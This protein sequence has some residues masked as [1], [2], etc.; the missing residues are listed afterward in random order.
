MKTLIILTSI[1]FLQTANAQVSQ[2]WVQRYNGAGNSEDQALASTVDASGNLYITGYATGPS[3]GKDYRTIKYNSAGVQQ[4]TTGLN[5]GSADDVAN[6]IAVDASGNVYVTGTY[7]NNFGTIKYNSAGTAQWLKIYNGTGN[8]TDEALCVKVDGTGNI[9]VTGYSTGV[10]AAGIDYVT[11]KYNSNGDSLWVKRYIGPGNGSD[12]PYALAIDASGNV[13]VTG[14]SKGSTSDLDYATVKY[15]P[16]GVEQWV[17][18]YNGPGNGVDVGRSIA[19]DAS[20]N[21][22]VTG[23]SMG[24]ISNYDYATIKYSSIGSQVWVKRYNGP[25]NTIDEPSSLILDNS[26]NVIVT[27]GSTGSGTSIDFA[28]IKY[29]SIGDSLWVRRYDGP[30]NVEDGANALAV[31]NSGNIYVAGFSVGAGTNLDYATIKYNSA[32]VQQWIQRYN[33]P[34]NDL[35]GATSMSLDVSGNV[36]VTGTSVGTSTNRDYATIKYSQTVGISQ[37]SSE[38]PKNF[39]LSQ[40]YPNPFNPTTKIKFAIPSVGN[41]NMQSVKLKIFNIL[42]KE[43]STIV[44]QQIQ[45]G[46]YEVEWNAAEVPSGTYFYKLTVDDFTETKKMILIK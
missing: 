39:S 18:R 7:N 36:Y 23:Y 16:A 28:T 31:D 20:G 19:V 26:N 37:I 34:G 22:Y 43:I 5:S 3:T 2:E 42:G 45:P 38:V 27:G 40:N 44:N 35:D 15:N 46:A 8:G 9:Y 10:G 41:S 25:A 13:Y 33:G 32:G 29:T 6:S 12:E 11:I 14:T 4:W 30:A 17:L 1:L 24:S 21:V